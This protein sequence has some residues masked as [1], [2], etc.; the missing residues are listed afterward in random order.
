MFKIVVILTQSEPFNVFNETYNNLK[1]ELD[2]EILFDIFDSARLDAEEDLYKECHE[3][4]EQADFIFMYLHGNVTNFKAFKEY[5]PILEG[6]KFFFHTGSEEEIREMSTKMN[7][8]PTEYQTILR[9]YLNADVKNMA[10]MFKYVMSEICNYE[11][12][13]FEVPS[14]PKFHGIYDPSKRTIDE[15]EYLS[16]IEKSEKPIIGILFHFYSFIN[17]DFEHVNAL[18]KAIRNLGGVPYCVYSQIAPDLELEFG[19]VKETFQK[20]F[21]S[22]EKVLIDALINLTQFSVNV[23]ANPGDGS[24]QQEGNVFEVLD[25]PVFQAMVSTYTYEE[26]KEAPAGIHPMTLP[27]CI[28]QPEF[29]G[30]LITFPIAYTEKYMENNEQKSKSIPIIGRVEKLCKL[31]MNWAVLPHIPKGEKKIAII[32]HNL[33]PRNDMIG[34]VSGLD[35]PESVYNMIEEL[36]KDGIVTEYTFKDGQ[37]IIKKIID[38]VTNDGRWS[39]EEDLLKKS[40]DTVNKEKYLSWFNSFPEEV[41]KKLTEDWGTPP[42]EYMAINDQ[43]LIPGIINGNIFIGLQPPRALTEKAEELVHSPDIVCPHQYIAFY[44]WVEEVFGANAVVHVGTH[45]T[46]EWLPGRDVALSESCYPDLTIGTLPNL[47]PFIISNPGE[48]VQAK[49]RSYCAILDYLIPSMVESGTYEELADIDTMMKEYYHFMLVDKSRVAAISKRIWDLACETNLTQDIGLTEEDALRHIDECMDKIHA[50]ISRIQS[51]EIADG[52]HIYGNIPQ[53]DRLKNLI[54]VLLRVKNGDIPSLREGIAEAMGYDLKHLLDYPTELLSIG[55]TNA[56]I[57]EEID[58]IG[59]EIFV[60]LQT[61]GYREE[62]IEHILNKEIWKKGRTCKLKQ[63]LLFAISEVKPKIEQTSR[64]LTSLI[65]GYNGKLVPTGLSGCPTRGNVHLLPTGKN[66]YTVDPGAIPS[67]SAWETGVKLAEQLLDRYLKDEGKIPENI[68]ILVLATES[69][70][71]TG[72]D[73]AEILYLYG[74]KPV[75]L[76]NSDRVIGIEVIPLS[77]L[78]RPRIDVTLKITGLFRD[79]F[80]NLI[81]MIEEAVNM[82]AVLEEP[83]EQNYVKKHVDIDMGKLIKEGMSKEQAFENSRLRIFGD[84]PGTHGTGVKELVYA[85]KWEKTED[86]GNVFTTWSSYAYGKNL[87]GEKRIEAF[88]TRFAAVD[89]AVKNESNIENDML[90]SDD[91]YNYFGG[92]VAAVTTHSGS[93]KPSYI[94]N[95]SNKENLEIFSLHEEA[96]KVMRARINNPK[97]IEGL[98]VHGYKGAQEISAMVDIVFGWDATTSVIDDWMYDAIA[99]RYAFN[100]ENAEWIKSVNLYALQNIAERLLEAH[101]RGMWNTSEENIKK[102]REIYLEVEGDIEET[103]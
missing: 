17:E 25:V 28:F 13:T 93:Q 24:N 87:H 7:L 73:I 62:V 34:C 64:E 102:L 42:G 38:G 52:L 85:K 79:T 23:I 67:R 50:W 36:S 96:S 43:I 92:L 48:G 31:V 103:N 8:H 53:G 76:G 83:H 74:L 94:P 12:Y 75:W 9:Y 47:Y 37:E 86:L 21:I 11:K 71:T 69:M 46:L 54:K 40:I 78:G 70:R 39:S 57:L 19:G 22:K 63:C 14:I 4:L 5:L 61:E 10:N 20:Y 59:R 80:P 32:F 72:D 1:N 15:M 58:E 16:N 51:Q 84:P 66:F 82:V 6:K 65:N 44:R 3:K 99:N 49:R 91:F 68:A 29:D 26:L 100:K 60:S 41:K 45:G 97:W 77:E 89:V 18:M 2:D 35:S 95:T 81:A 98:K 90:G 55:K 30:Q 33:P 88:K 101:Q 56:M 27:Y